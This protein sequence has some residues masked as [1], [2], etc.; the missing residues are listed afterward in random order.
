MAIQTTHMN[1][2]G[3][4]APMK[5]GQATPYLDDLKRLIPTLRVEIIENVGHF[6]QIERAG[7]L[8]AM[9]DSFLKGVK[10]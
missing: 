5:K 8:N 3:Q 1:A 9:L 7:E 6:P 4:R 2:A 10:A